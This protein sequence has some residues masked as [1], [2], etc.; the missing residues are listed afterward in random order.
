[1]D[2]FIKRG[3]MVVVV[4]ILPEIWLLQQQQEKL[5]ARYDDIYVWPRKIRMS[6]KTQEWSRESLMAATNLF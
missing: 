1:Q 6:R 4:N 2:R 5:D 3:N